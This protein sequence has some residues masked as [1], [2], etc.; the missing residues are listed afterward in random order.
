MTLFS[1]LVRKM[2]KDRLVLGAIDCQKVFIRAIEEKAQKKIIGTKE[3]KRAK[4]VKKI[5]NN[6]I[7]T[8]TL[9]IS[10]YLYLYSLI[11]RIFLI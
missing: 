3:T 11:Y 2:P 7:T 8:N 1:N 5:R 6:I 4:R 9:L 10:Y